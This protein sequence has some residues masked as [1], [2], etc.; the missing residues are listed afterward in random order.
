MTVG[1][2]GHFEVS[3]VPVGKWFLQLDTPHFAPNRDP[4]FPDF[5]R[6]VGTQLIPLTSSTPD[7]STLIA[8]RS[9]LVRTSRPTPVTANLSGLEPVVPGAHVSVV[10]A[11]ADVWQELYLD[12][13]ALGQTSV[14]VHLDWQMGF[15]LGATGLPDPAQGDTIF[16]YQRNL[17]DVPIANGTA[18]VNQA[19]R[20]ARLDALRV[21][22]GQPVTISVPMIEAPQTGM[23]R[24]DVKTTR[25]A[26][27]ASEV[28]PDG[29]I[30]FVYVSVSAVPHGAQYPEEPRFSARSLFSMFTSVASDVQLAFTYGQFLDAPWQEV[31]TSGFVFESPN[32]T[33]RAGYIG[34]REPLGPAT[35]QVVVPV[36]SPPTHPRIN[37]QDAF[38]PQAGV[39]LQPTI[40][41]SPPR[42]GSPTSYQLTVRIPTFGVR[43]G[44]TDELSVIVDG[45][46]F[47][48]PPGFLRNNR[49]YIATI[50]AQQ[51]PWDGPGRLPLRSGVP[52]YTAD[53]ITVG[54]S[55]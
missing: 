11:Q 51:A 25:F 38:A 40:S 12:R 23:L 19:V 9:D 3:G 46:S 5:V 31:R 29:Q 41:W 17:A 18:H 49:G 48:I 33:D 1:A 34:I 54:F 21:L 13:S 55:P 39:G 16:W 6:A 35:S 8:A 52:P 26:E 14:Q 44:D 2:D 27:L 45:T 22:D 36:L 7:L 37:G 10:S 28:V 42:I 47:T 4:R 30:S 43:E 15:Q 50:T 20:Y 32:F 53:C 24:L